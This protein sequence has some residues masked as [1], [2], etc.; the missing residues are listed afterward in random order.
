MIV[1]APDKRPDIQASRSMHVA[2]AGGLEISVKISGT[3]VNRHDA[4]IPTSIM[5]GHK[6]RHA[7][8]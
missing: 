7:R 8:S 1:V 5:H 4:M 3:D 2:D 6:I